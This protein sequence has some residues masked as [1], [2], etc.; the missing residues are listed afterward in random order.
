MPSESTEFDL[1][2]VL[3]ILWRRK[4]IVVSTVVVVT[5]AAYLVKET[6]TQQQYRASAVVQ[7]KPQQVD[8]SLFDT[9]NSAAG[10]GTLEPVTRVITTTQFARLAAK[11]LK[12]PADPRALLEQITARPSNTSNTINIGAD[13]D[14]A[15]RAADIAN[16]FARETVKSRGTSARETVDLAIKQLNGQLARI[17]N[18][19][20]RGQLSRQLQRLRAVRAGQNN[21]AQ[22][23]EPAFRGEP[24]DRRVAKS[25]LTAFLISILVGLALALLVDRL[26]RRIRSERELESLTGLPLLSTVPLS[27]FPTEAGGG[28]ATATGA[29]A[30]PF[31]RLRA[32]LIY[33][34]V[35][36][37][38][39]SV[40]ITSP[41]SQE[42][43]T[44]IALNLALAAARQGKNVL[45]VDADLHRPRVHERLG[46][47]AARGLSDVLS[48][49]ASLD[50]SI[51]TFQ[52][53][54]GRL[55]VLPAG[56][57]PPNPSEL[58][59]SERMQSLLETPMDLI[60]LDTAPL[61]A[62]SDAIPLL[63]QV[64]GVIVAARIDATSRDGVKRVAQT[65][66]TAEGT[67]LGVV[68][69]GVENPESYG[70]GYGYGYAESANG[71][72]ETEEAA[73]RPLGPEQE[74]S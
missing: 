15:K 9:T 10:P 58:L 68:A 43:K 18:P 51:Q 39:K 72:G 49:N 36:Q 37:P 62:V 30:E 16:A 45:L 12:P 24:I 23:L 35:S 61:L 4:W 64:S 44:T 67:V 57:V 11:R 7:V 71:H 54:D 60:V 28:V 29:D 32:G 25:T 14:N 20:E 34:N 59:A 26:D 56:K 38:V 73:L 53:G 21:N 52:A 19:Q 6:T 13:A 65:V 63:K 41:G 5:A 17:N 40:L 31:R 70:Y 50:D 55:S 48:A 74:R 66:R 47:E 69:T 2:E 3:R 46:L 42:G 8:Q 22:L 1:Q 27:A 33:F